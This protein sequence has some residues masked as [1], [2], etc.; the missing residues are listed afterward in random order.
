VYLPRASIWQPP[1]PERPRRLKV[2]WADRDWWFAR[3]RRDMLPWR[4]APYPDPQDWE[5]R[6]R[7]RRPFLLTLRGWQYG[8]K[9]E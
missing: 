3:S 2:L 5:P 9:W 7:H 6:V 8:I 4:S 1:L